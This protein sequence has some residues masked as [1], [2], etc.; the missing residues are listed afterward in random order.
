M[1]LTKKAP[2][3]NLQDQDGKYHSLN[4]YAGKWLVV[5]IYPKDGTP[6]CTKEAC[7]FRDGRDLLAQLGAEVV[8]ISKDSVESHNKFHS[9]HG[10]NH[11][12]LSDLNGETIKNFQSLKTKK[13]MGKEFTS[14]SRDTFII[15]PSGEIVKRYMG[16]N[17]ITHFVKVFE[18]LKKL[19]SL[20]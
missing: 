6:G 19:V 15:N 16:V 9:K 3:F 7:S 20:E 4:D 1:S 17:P 18:D 13:I 10:L 8:G 2:E 12:I 5:Y 14:V 11:T